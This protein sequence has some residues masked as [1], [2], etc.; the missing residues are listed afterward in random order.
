MSSLKYFLLLESLATAET[1]V[2]HKSLLHSVKV[3]RGLN[4]Y[5]VS[6]RRE[7]Q[8]PRRQKCNNMKSTV[9]QAPRKF[10]QPL[11]TRSLRAS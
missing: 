6:D 11:N 8:I 10:S 3:S 4:Q 1:I 2:Q 9:S 7:K 5:P